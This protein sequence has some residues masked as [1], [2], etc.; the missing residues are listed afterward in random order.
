[1]LNGIDNFFGL[2]YDSVHVVAIANVSGLIHILFMRKGRVVD[3]K[4]VMDASTSS[5]LIG[6]IGIVILDATFTFP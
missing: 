3:C 5:R 4:D 2:R 1:M 6:I